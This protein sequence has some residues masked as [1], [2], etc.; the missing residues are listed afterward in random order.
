M[1]ER[2]RREKPEEERINVPANPKNYWR[3]RMHLTVE[4]LLAASEFNRDLRRALQECTRS[5]GL[6]NNKLSVLQVLCVQSHSHHTV[7]S[8]QLTPRHSQATMRPMR[9]PKAL[10]LVALLGFALVRIFNAPSVSAA[11]QLDKPRTYIYVLRLTPKF[12]DEHA[13]TKEDHVVAQ[14]HFERLKAA[15]ERGPVILAG[16]TDEPADKTFGIVIFEAPDAAAARVF[17]END[18][19][20]KAGIMTAE[21]HPYLVA[22]Q[23]SK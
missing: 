23:R 4:K 13:W 12:H 9:S 5:P 10:F 3:Y 1:D 16:R 14:R 8:A 18:P 17:M 22:V 6:P 2:L 20:V 15:A 19:A 7:R 21:L 11:E